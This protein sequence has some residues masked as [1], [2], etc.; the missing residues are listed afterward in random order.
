MGLDSFSSPDRAQLQH[1]RPACRRRKVGNFVGQA[2]CGGPLTT[3]G[4]ARRPGKGNAHPGLL[5]ERMNL[6]RECMNE[7]AMSSAYGGGVSAP[8]L[9]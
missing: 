2:L 7:A 4:M 1:L 9:G 5:R 6:L 8:A 3:M